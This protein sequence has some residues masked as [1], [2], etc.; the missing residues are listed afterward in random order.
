MRTIVI[1]MSV[2][3]IQIF[4]TQLVLANK[5]LDLVKEK[6]FYGAAN[7]CESMANKNN[8]NAQFAL[9]TLYF[10]GNGMMQDNSQALTWFRKAAE[11]NHNQAQ[12]NLGIMLANG[13]SIEADLVEAYAWLKISKNNGYSPA[14]EVIK[15][16]GAE[17]SS[18]EKKQTEAKISELKKEFKLGI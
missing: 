5:C 3:L 9:A 4:L 12:Y 11:N 8:A 6:D 18:T 17:L 2:L 14:G 7:V 1:L 16:L 15:Q 13:M 10:D